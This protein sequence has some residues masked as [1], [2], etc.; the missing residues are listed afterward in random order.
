MHAV[1]ATK[2]PSKVAA[3]K[4]APKVAATKP[5]PKV[6]AAKPAPKVAAT[7]PAPKVA[8]TKPAAPI[9]STK[10]AAAVA[11]RAPA[12]PLAAETA[13]PAPAGDAA[14]PFDVPQ[15]LRRFVELIRST[16]QPNGKAAPELAERL[17]QHQREVTILLGREPAA[18]SIPREDLHAHL[19]SQAIELLEYERDPSTAVGRQVKEALV[20]HAPVKCSRPPTAIDASAR[21]AQ[22]AL[23][24][25]GP[26]LVRR[27]LGGQ[28]EVDRVEVG[29]YSGSKD[30]DVQQIIAE[31]GR[32]GGEVRL[33]ED[34]DVNTG[35]RI[36]GAPPAE[37]RVDADG[38][39]I[40]DID[41][42]QDHALGALARQRA[43]F[44]LWLGIRQRLEREGRG[45]REA[46]HEALGVMRSLDYRLDS[47]RRALS[48]EQG[49][50]DRPSIF[51]TGPSLRPRGPT[52]T[53][54]I[55]RICRPEVETLRDALVMIAAAEQQVHSNIDAVR[56]RTK[57]RSLM[58]KVI[59]VAQAQQR[60]GA[61]GL[62]AEAQQQEQGGDRRGA[63]RTRWAACALR[64]R[65]LF[66]LIFEP[67]AVAAFQSSGTLPAL[68]SLYEEVR[69]LPA[70]GSVAPPGSVEH[71]ASTAPTDRQER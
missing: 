32:A 40:I 44:L 1:P 17:T 69:S 50:D 64:E 71:R 16:D 34:R 31:L 43:H 3:A 42:M 23:E 60:E 21:A 68:R 45:E 12:T 49:A 46:A 41:L 36:P 4:P 65:S 33:I 58:R 29:C 35:E 6:A 10:P 47:E 24:A 25:R 15:F 39:P 30:A 57:A 14:P 2:P 63:L 38:R 53:H 5:A 19:L 62:A 67:G 22:L 7:K 55:S 13:R 11:A 9:P 26:T 20:E 52:D 27:V 61:V 59:E 54:Y 18:P 70:A 48:A 8:A 37:L 51:S 56:A 66:D 28:R